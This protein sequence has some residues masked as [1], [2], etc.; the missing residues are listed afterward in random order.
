MRQLNFTYDAQDRLIEEVRDLIDRQPRRHPYEF[1]DDDVPD[2][3]LAELDR[4]VQ[5]TWD[6]GDMRTKAIEHETIC[7]LLLC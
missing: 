7:S 4:T 1:A 3:D 6:D 2:A 5:G